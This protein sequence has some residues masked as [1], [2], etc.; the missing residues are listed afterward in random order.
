[1]KSVK[2][3]DKMFLMLLGY[4][5]MTYLRK[6]NIKKQQYTLVKLHEIS[7]KFF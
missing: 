7:N 2:L 3:K 5:Q 6:E 1:M 4:T